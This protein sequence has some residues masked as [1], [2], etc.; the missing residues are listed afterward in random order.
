MLSVAVP[1][2]HQLLIL[3]APDLNTLIG[4]VN[5][6]LEAVCKRS[7]TLPARPTNVR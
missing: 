5:G 6:V 1:I 7:A 4:N 3:Q 2:T